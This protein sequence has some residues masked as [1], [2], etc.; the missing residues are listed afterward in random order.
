MQAHADQLETA[1]AASQ[2]VVK[3]RTAALDDANSELENLKRENDEALAAE[4][5]KEKAVAA[6]GILLV[7]FLYKLVDLHMFKEMRHMCHL[8]KRNYMDSFRLKAHAEKAGTSPSPPFEPEP[9]PV[10]IENNGRG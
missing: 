2:A 1:L 3:E 7:S 8:W 10:T 9:L 5:A 6:A 4:K